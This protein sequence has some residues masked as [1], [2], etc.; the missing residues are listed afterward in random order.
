MEVDMQKFLML[1]CCLLL[2]LGLVAEN[3]KQWE[4]TFG[5]YNPKDAKSSTV[6]GVGLMNAFDDQVEVGLSMN[7]YFKTY[8]KDTR[9]DSLAGGIGGVNETTLVTVMEFSRHYIPIML[10][11]RYNLPVIFPVDPFVSAG[12]G[13]GMLFSNE[14]NYEMGEEDTRFYHGF[15]WQ[16]SGGARYQLGSRSAFLVELF[17]L[18]GKPSREREKINGMPAYSEVNMSGL[19][20]RAG[21]RLTSF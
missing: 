5:A 6:F 18:G 20:V 15:S 11:F 10:Q 7:Y 12:L 19:G 2:F 3:G 1:I 13:Y 17:Y 4:L 9:V 21:L 8:Q 16:L 14:K